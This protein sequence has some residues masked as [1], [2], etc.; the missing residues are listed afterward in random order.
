MLFE[1][2]VTESVAVSDSAEWF[3][4]RGLEGIIIQVRSAQNRRD[5]YT[6]ISLSCSYFQYLGK[7]LSGFRLNERKDL[8]DVIKQLYEKKM[9]D[10]S[11][12]DDMNKINIWSRIPFQHNGLAFEFS[13][14]QLKEQEGL[15]I[16]ALKCLEYLK[17]YRRK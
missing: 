15:T 1:R 8:G 3:I 12:R 14:K 10:Q 5:Y 17:R 6:A 16:L 2:R 13:S 11:I 7:Q 9:I 4:K